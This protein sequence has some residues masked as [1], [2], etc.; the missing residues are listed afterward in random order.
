MFMKRSLLLF[1]SLFAAVSAPS[2]EPEPG[3]VKWR[4]YA[5]GLWDDAPKWKPSRIP[6]AADS[7]TF[8]VLPAD[9][10][11]NPLVPR[12]VVTSTDNAARAATAMRVS[13]SWV[14]LRNFDLTLAGDSGFT[15][16]LRIENGGALSV[17]AVAPLPAAGRVNFTTAGAAIGLGAPVILGPGAVL[18][19]CGLDIAPNVLWKNT[20]SVGIGETM[21][22]GVFIESRFAGGVRNSSTGKILLG[23]ADKV[24]GSLSV[25]GDF[26]CGDIR[27][28]AHRGGIGDVVVQKGGL[29]ESADAFLAPLRGSQAFAVV[30]DGPFEQDGSFSAYTSQGQSTNWLAAS[31]EISGLAN[32]GAGSPEG[33]SGYMFI[34]D[35][36]VVE[37]LSA[38]FGNIRPR[39]GVLASE[40]AQVVVDGIDPADKDAAM[41][42]ID[43]PLVVG[44]F[45]RAVV[46]V[47]GGAGLFASSIAVKAHGT[48]RARGVSRDG[49]QDIVTRSGIGVA[50][51]EDAPGPLS[52]DGGGLFSLA[53][54]AELDCGDLTI[55]GGGGLA[56]RC[57]LNESDPALADGVIHVGDVSVGTA[58]E[59]PGLLELTAATVSVN[60]FVTIETGSKLSGSGLFVFR[61]AAGQLTNRGKIIILPG[62]GK[63]LQIGGDYVQ[64]G[65]GRLIV[66]INKKNDAG[67]APLVV[68]GTTVQLNGKI[69]LRFS[70][71]RLPRSGEAF[72]LIRAEN[73][74]ITNNATVR[75]T[76]AA[77][78]FDVVQDD[79]SIAVVFR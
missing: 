33:G 15:D 30:H 40:V 10:A 14:N 66:T 75:V 34:T 50:W 21:T 5:D 3:E 31:L 47:Q 73:A 70:G 51:A 41:L 43:G 12:F 55:G 52:I 49:A 56:A 42:S 1:C 22:G 38:S 17:D 59:F 76:G 79:F 9:V 71:N 20:G 68:L 64:P 46:M 23:L 74:T 48:L 7:V 35:G 13:R 54:G 27:A 53:A 19:F 45:S 58:P 28:G 6:A 4:S 39:N 2:A 69:E 32:G 77:R 18:G 57:R 60:Q 26:L 61:N 8:S 16:G 24:E 11:R 63:T 29:L 44:P 37:A 65:T 78:G 62:A 25:Y 36:G 72:A 67:S